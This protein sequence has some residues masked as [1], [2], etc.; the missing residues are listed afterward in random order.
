[1]SRCFCGR[2]AKFACGRIANL[3]C[4]RVMKNNVCGRVVAPHE[5]GATIPAVVSGGEKART[6]LSAL[7]ASAAPALQVLNSRTITFIEMC[8]GSE[9]GSDL[10][11]IDFMY[12]ATIPAVVSGGEEGCTT[13]SSLGAS[14]TPTPP[15]LNLRTTKMC[16]GSEAGSNLGLLDFVYRST[17]RGREGPHATLCSRRLRCTCQGGSGFALRWAGTSDLI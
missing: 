9:T 8:K 6:T 15:V 7:G 16:R 5:N 17:Q 12:H 10:G 3:V 2:F 4:G 14:T 13:P 1:M 11:L